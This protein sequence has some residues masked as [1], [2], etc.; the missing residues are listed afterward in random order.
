M[1]NRDGKGQF[2]KENTA[3]GD[4]A[5]F[6]CPNEEF[7]FEAEFNCPELDQEIE[8]ECEFTI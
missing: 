7:E 3:G 5:E 4:L 1:E 8:F 2:A 6:D